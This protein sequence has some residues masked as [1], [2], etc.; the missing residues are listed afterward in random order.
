ME[1]SIDTS[2]RHASVGLSNEG[3]SRAEITWRS[4]RNHSVELVPAIRRLMS[5]SCS[6]L[7]KVKAI[8]V[9][10]GPGGFSALRVGMSSAKALA[11]ALHIPLVAIGS[12]DIEA[13]PYLGIGKPVT[14][15]V[16]A[17]RD[18]F[19]LGIYSDATDFGSVSYDI[20]NFTQL[21]SK[22]KANS[23][24]CGEG[25]HSIAERLKEYH[26]HSS[27]ICDVP[28]PT[29]RQSVLS[30]L[31][32]LRL[33]ANDTDN[34]ASIEPIYIRSAQVDTAQQAWTRHQS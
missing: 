2:T 34:P 11:V 8:F 9:A 29:R 33:M 7:K 5:H 18:R 28:P 22:V 20:V 4:E 30:H 32:Y 26:G 15:I 23:V 24:L 27:L 3:Q 25:I 19:Y 17:G 1:L 10:K 16:N 12:L 6:D 13:Q 31:A 21:V 14:V